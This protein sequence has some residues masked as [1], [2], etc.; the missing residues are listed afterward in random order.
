MNSLF[1]AAKDYLKRGWTPI[2]VGQ[3]KKPKIKW[4]HWQSHKPLE[5]DLKEWWSMYP[6]SQVGIVAGKLSDIAVIDIDSESGFK[7]IRELAGETFQAPTVHTPKGGRHLYCR[8]QPGL[9]NNVRGVD[10]VD[11]RGEGGYVVAPPSVNGHGKGWVWDEFLGI[12]TPIPPLPPAYVEAIRQVDRAASR[13]ITPTALFVAGRRNEDLFSLALSMARGRSRR[14]EIY[15]YC[16]WVASQTGMDDDINHLVASALERAGRGEKNLSN[17]VRDFVGATDGSFLISEVYRSLGIDG[18]QEKNAVRAALHRMRQEGL[19]EK[20]GKRDG[21]YRKLAKD[22]LVIDW[23]NAPTSEYDVSLPMDLNSLISV[24]PQN[25]LVIAGAPNSGKTALCI[26]IAKR[27]MNTRRVLYFSSEMGDAETKLRLSK[28]DDCKVDDWKVEFY[29]RSDN[30][31]DVIDPDALNIID[32][33]EAPA[34]FYRI[35]EYMGSI[36]SKLRKGIAVISIQKTKGQDLGRGGTF[37][38][39]K[40]RLYLSLDG[41]VAKIVKAKNWKGDLNPNG[42]IMQFNIIQGAKIL[43]QSVWHYE[44]DEE[45]AGLKRPRGMFG[46]FSR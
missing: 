19:L 17:D 13:I 42:K 18:K 20:G 7:K 1:V 14:E 15:S 21:E 38:S 26:D 31:S 30:F 40:P 35:G 28:H 33:L 27:N 36:F 6:D 34:E 41:G 29:E 9:G 11:L 45:D 46:R 25:L 16:S 32:Y 2:P 24:Y 22:C 4:E 44:T 23:K 12:D 5:Q 3:D 10:G 43:P 37:S 39:E 8:W